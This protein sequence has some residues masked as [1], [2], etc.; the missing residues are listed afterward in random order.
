VQRE[1]REW[2]HEAERCPTRPRGSTAAVD[3][4]NALAVCDDE[5][6]QRARPSNELGETYADEDLSYFVDE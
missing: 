1:T 4:Q 5:T 2:K 3:E 6:V